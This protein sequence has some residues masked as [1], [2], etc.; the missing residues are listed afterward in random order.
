MSCTSPL[1]LSDRIVPCGK[2]YSCLLRRVNTWVVRLMEQQKIAQS[3]HFITLTYEN[4][5]NDSASDTARITPNGRRTLVKRDLQLFF[6]GLRSLSKNDK[7][8]PIKYYCCGEYG[9]RSKRPHY[10]A[11]VFNAAQDNYRKSWLHGFVHVG[12]VTSSSIAYCLKYISKGRVVPEDSNDDRT[13]EFALMSKGLGSNYVTD[14]A[15]RWHKADLENRAHIVMDGG[16]KFPLPRY[17]RE[18]IYSTEEQAKLSRSMENQY[19]D[20]AV[21]KNPEGDHKVWLDMKHQ[22]KQSALADKR[23]LNFKK[24]ENEKI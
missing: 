11:I 14:S 24:I 20:Q 6:K 3:A 5:T 19:I 18:K 23:I 4:E 21:E 13:K 17:L 2:C 8:F 16:V 10:H 15:K 7:R 9:S 1:K 12:Q 22:A